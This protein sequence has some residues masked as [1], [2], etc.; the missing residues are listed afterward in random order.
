M[1]MNG[2]NPEDMFVTLKNMKERLPQD[3][4]IHPGH[5]YSVKET[6]T[7]SDQVEG[8]PFMHYDDAEAFVNYRMH[9]HDKTRDEP[10]DAVSK[11]QLK[12]ANLL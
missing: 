4:L 10:Y 6:C 7:L 3:M 2:G 11:Q 9:V 8:D 5:N 12:I 1:N